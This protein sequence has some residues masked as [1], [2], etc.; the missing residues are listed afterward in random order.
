MKK[1][2]NKIGLTKLYLMSFSGFIIA[3]LFV[4]ISPILLGSSYSYAETKV[5]EYQT[6]SNSLRIALVKKEYNPEKEIMRLDY[7]IEE[8]N[9]NISLPNIDYEITSQY[10]KGKKKLEVSLTKV[11]DTYLVVIIKGVPK[12]YSVLSTTIIPKYIHT[13]L[14]QVNDLKDRSFKMYVNESEEIINNSLKIETEK[15]YKQQYITFQQELL[16]RKME[17]NKKEI[18][19]N[20]LAIEEINTLVSKLKK[21][22]AYQTEDEKLET[23]NTINSHITTVKQHENDIKKLKEALNGLKEKIDLLEEKR[24]S[25]DI[26][27]YTTN[28]I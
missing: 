19:T 12:G 20:E 7:S 10:I 11:D 22:L 2:K 18:E 27:P 3:F 6:L 15:D 24:K 21:D 1:K 16:K 5:N 28:G 9:T 4:F 26:T 14:Q 25:F 13:E 23:S 17:E 8:T